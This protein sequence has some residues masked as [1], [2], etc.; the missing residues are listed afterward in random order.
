MTIDALKNLAADVGA[1]GDHAQAERLLREALSRLER[2][3]TDQAQRLKEQG[4]ILIKD[5]S[6]ERLLQGDPVEADKLLTEAA[7][8]AARVLGPDHHFTL[9]I[10]RV[11][12]RVLAEEGQ[13]AKAEP[14]AKTTLEPR[15]RPTI[16]PPGHD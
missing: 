15:R 2:N 11:L 14:L 13:F 3:R 7:P 10:Q 8:Q 16:D 12:A 1:R 5:L 4:F 6:V 9:H